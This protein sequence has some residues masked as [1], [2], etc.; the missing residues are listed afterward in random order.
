MYCDHGV[1]VAKSELVCSDLLSGS[2]W[3]FMVMSTLQLGGAFPST[4]RQTRTDSTQASAL[5]IVVWVLQ[6]MWGSG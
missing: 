5:K 2:S 4:G 6:H 1:F 3:D